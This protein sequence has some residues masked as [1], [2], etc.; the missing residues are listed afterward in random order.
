MCM[1]ERNVDGNI[2]HVTVSFAKSSG[3]SIQCR[4]SRALQTA[5]EVKSGHRRSMTFVT[6]RH[7][8]MKREAFLHPILTFVQGVKSFICPCSLPA[9]PAYLLDCWGISLQQLYVEQDLVC[10]SITLKGQMDLV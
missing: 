10:D 6:G 8:E 1:V 7:W 4:S 2:L 9:S 5:L 3:L